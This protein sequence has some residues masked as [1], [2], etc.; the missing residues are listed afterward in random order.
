MYFGEFSSKSINGKLINF[1][2]IK[3]DN[4]GILTD[5]KTFRYKEDNENTNNYIQKLVDIKNNIYKVI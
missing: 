4:S 2:D 5:N 1:N 3:R